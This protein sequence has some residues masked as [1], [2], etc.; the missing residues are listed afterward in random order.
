MKNRA[1]HILLTVVTTALLT[2]A[3][4][5]GKKEPAPAPQE[6]APASQQPADETPQPAD[7]PPAPQ[8]PAAVEVP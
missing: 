8:K 7:A 1:A 3:V 2:L 4:G 6:P 5:C